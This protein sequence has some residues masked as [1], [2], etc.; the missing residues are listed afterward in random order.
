LFFHSWWRR[1]KPVSSIRKSFVDAKEKNENYSHD[2]RCNALRS[3][4]T[5][6]TG[7]MA[8]S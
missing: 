8:A 7:M 6:E 1:G 3:T 5:A 4:P 2:S